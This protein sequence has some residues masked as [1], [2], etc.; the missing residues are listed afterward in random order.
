MLAIRLPKE[1]E[2]RLG[3]LA[4]LT[5]LPCETVSLQEDS[6]HKNPPYL[7]RQF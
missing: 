4:K 1:T 7:E 2:D 6:L 5:N 3:K